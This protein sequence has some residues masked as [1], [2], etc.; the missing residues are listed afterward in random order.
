[1]LAILTVGRLVS[2]LVIGLGVV[3]RSR[4]MSDE[5]LATAAAWSAARLGVCPAPELLA[6]SDVD[7]PAIWC[8]GRRPAILLPE[9]AETAARV[10]WAGVFCHELA[11]WV[12]R[13]Q[14]SSLLGEVLVC[15]LPWHPLAWWAKHRLGQ[16]SELAC[17]DWVLGTGLPAADYAESLLGLVP[18]RRAP[19]PWRRYRAVADSSAASSTS[20][21]SGGA[22]RSSANA[23]L[24][25]ARR[26]SCW[27]HRRWRWPR[28]GRRC[29]RTKSARTDET[30]KG[31]ASK[32]A[33]VSN[34]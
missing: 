30:E 11:H 12:R 34:Q 29:R 18:Q 31:N 21:M 33:P 13:D 25:P 10:D 23:G 5:A 3:R 6:S 19:W 20:W 8:W 24:A 15:A 7:C 4:Q 1:M 16:L 26:R 22:A 28:A 17:D 32:T 27:R 9:A 14:W 2:S